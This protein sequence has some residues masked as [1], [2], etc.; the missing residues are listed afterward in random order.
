MSWG[1]RPAAK[2]GSERSLCAEGHSHRSKLESAVCA[3]YSLRKKAGEILSIGV[4]KHMR[5]CGPLGHDCSH[6]I[7]VE[8][9]VD[10]ELTRIDG[11][12]FYGEAKGMETTDYRIKRRL[13]MH[14]SVGKLE[15]WKGNWQRPVLDE[16]II[17]DDKEAT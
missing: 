17:P 3:Q 10:F 12:I 4:E 1:R 15:I 14:H 7:K 5:V 8:L 9:I 6:A 16:V 11:S 13:W 2:Y